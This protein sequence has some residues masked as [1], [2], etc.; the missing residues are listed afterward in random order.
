MGK[1]MAEGMAKVA[2]AT[3][4]VAAVQMVVAGSVAMAVVEAGRT[5]TDRRRVW[6]TDRNCSPAD[7]HNP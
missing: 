5:G 1:A 4:V 2:M 6:P 7:R 3:E